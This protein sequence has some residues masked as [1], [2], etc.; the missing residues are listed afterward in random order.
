MSIFS[1]NSNCVPLKAYLR[2]DSHSQ[3]F[4]YSNKS[5]ELVTKEMFW[6][7]AQNEGLYLDYH[8]I[9]NRRIDVSVGISEITAIET[10]H[11]E[12]CDQ[13]ISENLYDSLASRLYVIR[14]Y[15]GCGKSTFINDLMRNTPSSNNIYIDIG[16]DWSYPQEPFMFFNEVLLAFDLLVRQIVELTRTRDKIWKKFI[17]IGTGPNIELLD[18]E[19]KNIISRFENIKKEKR[20]RKLETGLHSFLFNYYSGRDN[21]QKMTESIWHNVG[22]VQTVVSLIILLHCSKSI[23]ENNTDSLSII[24]DNLDVITNPTIPAENVILLWGVIDK[25]I[26][27]SEEYNKVNHQ[28]ITNVKMIIAVRKVLYS[29]IISYL[30]DLE[31]LAHFVPN[32]INICDISDLYLSQEILIHRIVYWRDKIQDTSIKKKFDRLIELTSVHSSDEYPHDNPS[33]IKLTINLDAFFN[34]NYRAFANILS[35]FIDNPKYFDILTS[36]SKSNLKTQ[37]WQNVST[38]VFLVSLLYRKEKVWNTMGFGCKDFDTIDYPTTLNRLILNYLFNAKRG[39]YLYRRG[40]MRDDILTDETVSLKDLLDSFLNSK[41]IKIKTYY[42]PQKINEKY[43]EPF[44]NTEEILIDRLADMCARNPM[45]KNTKASGYDS[46]DD[47]LW[48]RP[49]YFTCGVKL[50]HTASSKEELKE[51]FTDSIKNNTANK[52]KFSITDEG[53]ILIRDVVADF[54]FYSARYCDESFLKPLYQSINS[55]EI[56]CLIKPVYNAIK[57]CCIRNGVFRKQYCNDY[58]ISINQYL[59]RDFHTRTNPRF[60]KYGIKSLSK[61][62]YREQLHIVRVIYN[63]CDYFDTVKDYFYNTNN[64]ER[65]EICKALTEWIRLYLDLYNTY[66]YSELEN[67]ICN[68]DNNIYNDLLQLLKEQELHYKKGSEI[69]NIRIN[70][71]HSFAKSN[72]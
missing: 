48:R 11:N 39:N 50:N 58:S 40:I 67:T 22:Q 35:I 71:W 56:N 6:G 25:F 10:K 33:E 2:A 15:A 31:M 61:N 46:D 19:L 21:V 20:W 27:F 45:S 8:L 32:N 52:I 26:R 51:Y 29:H 9:N 54:E 36:D 59:K 43:N 38:Q 5:G 72:T 47:E 65:I 30:P 53:F 3:C 34:H 49:L 1:I 42:S 44:S 64:P 66:F 28:K 7:N 55:N 14:G 12:D 37:N 17:E 16:R 24:F 70:R 23:I 60:N 4:Q 68:S 41:F 62:S 63:H 18:I 13:W 57:T 69:K